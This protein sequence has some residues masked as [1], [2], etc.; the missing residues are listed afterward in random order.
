LTKK[1]E[2]IKFL[3]RKKKNIEWQQIWK[4]GEHKDEYEDEDE[5]DDVNDDR[6]VRC[7][8][9]TLKP[10]R[11][12]LRWINEHNRFF[13]P[14]LNA[15]REYKEAVRQEEV[16]RIRAIWIREQT[17]VI[18]DDI[19]AEMRRRN[20]GGTDDNSTM[21]EKKRRSSSGLCDDNRKVKK[22]RMPGEAAT[23]EADLGAEEKK[24]I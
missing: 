15:A 6:L 22:S 3:T 5:E 19:M 17:G 8:K 4:D 18:Q 13:V 12:A 24:S 11:Q 21:A 20:R 9:W 14:F 7:E 16:H 23:V 2:N 10:I 1:K